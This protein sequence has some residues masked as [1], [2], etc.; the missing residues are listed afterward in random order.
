MSVVCPRVLHNVIY[1]LKLS[2]INPQANWGRV[3]TFRSIFYLSFYP[4]LLK[5]TMAD[6]SPS[7]SALHWASVIKPPLFCG[8][9]IPSVA[10]CS[11]SI[12]TLC[13]EEGRV[14]GCCPTSN[15]KRCLHSLLWRLT[16]CTSILALHPSHTFPWIF[17]FIYWDEDNIKHVCLKITW[18]IFQGQMTKRSAYVST[19]HGRA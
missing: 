11:V 17:G 9:E 16:S 8:E 5:N 13:G 10:N 18:C 7:G 6:M 4:H 3:C 14:A 19:S 12:C 1:F 15:G 2:F